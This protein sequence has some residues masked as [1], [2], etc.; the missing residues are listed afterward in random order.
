MGLTIVSH[1]PHGAKLKNL[2][3]NGRNGLP[4]LVQRAAHAG[5]FV[6]SI[7]GGNSIQEGGRYQ[8]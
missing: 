2:P 3:R 7:C 6:A 1:G 4:V 8:T 5:Q